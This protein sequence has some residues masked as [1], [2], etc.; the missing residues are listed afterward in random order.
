M[1]KTEAVTLTADHTHVTVLD[2]GREHA[3]TFRAGRHS[4]PP[5]VV[6]TARAAGLVVEDEAEPSAPVVSTRKPRPAK[7]AAKRKR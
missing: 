2:D 1:S 3:H 7:S 4:L 5:E 6:A